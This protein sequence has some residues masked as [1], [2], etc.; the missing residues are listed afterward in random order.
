MI[1][2]QQLIL[3]RTVYRMGKSH[4]GMTQELLG[5]KKSLSGNS[6]IYDSYYFITHTFK[7]LQTFKLRHIL[8]LCFTALLDR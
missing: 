8:S 6:P 2:I 4:E 3:E 1:Q 5:G 7:V